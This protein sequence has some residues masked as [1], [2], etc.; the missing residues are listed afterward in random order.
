[1]IARVPP[2]SPLTFLRS[3]FCLILAIDTE[4]GS[5]PFLYASPTIVTLLYYRRRY[6]PFLVTIIF[7]LFRL[8]SAE[9]SV[10]CVNNETRLKTHLPTTVSLTA[11]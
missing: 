11:T 3:V 7:H 5:F 9:E 8:C 10:H 4:H 1:M 2:I 6:D